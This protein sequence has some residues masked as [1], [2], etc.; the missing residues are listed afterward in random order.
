MG[1]NSTFVIILN[2][3][4]RSI[5]CWSSILVSISQEIHFLNFQQFKTPQEV[6][7]TQHNITTV[8]LTSLT[9]KRETFGLQS[10]PSQNKI[11]EQPFRM[12][13]LLECLTKAQ[14]SF[15]S[16]LRKS[17]IFLFTWQ[18]FIHAIYAIYKDY[19]VVLVFL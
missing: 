8:Y 14:S 18:P 6:N 2:I 9:Y 19:Q 13:K 5:V 12:I 3:H 17:T 10:I 1:Q 11:I 7:A 16:W 4:M 15:K